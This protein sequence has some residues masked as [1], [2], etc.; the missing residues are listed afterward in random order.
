MHTTRLVGAAAALAAVSGATAVAQPAAADG[1]ADGCNYG[2]HSYNA[3]DYRGGYAGCRGHDYN[4]ST[5]IG[6]TPSGWLHI[7][8][9]QQVTAVAWKRS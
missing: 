2:V 4:G 6:Y 8:L 3:D 9:D 5:L 1:V 7:Y